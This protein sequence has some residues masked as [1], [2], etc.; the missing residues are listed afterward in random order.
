MCKRALNDL[1]QFEKDKKA[2]VFVNGIEGSQEPI[3]MML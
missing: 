2:L 3:W 1:D